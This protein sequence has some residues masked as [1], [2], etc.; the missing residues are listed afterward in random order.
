VRLRN[1]FTVAVPSLQKRNGEYTILLSE[2]L[3]DF[4][5]A[6]LTTDP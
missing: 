5:V 4:P 6:L 1:R 2:L 3:A